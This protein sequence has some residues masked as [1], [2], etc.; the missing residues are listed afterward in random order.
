MNKNFALSA[1]VAAVPVAFAQGTAPSTN[2]QLYG[3]VDAGVTQTTGLRG[4]SRPQLVSGIMEGTRWGMRGNEDLGG[5]Y[6][7]DLQP[8]QLQLASANGHEV[9]TEPFTV[10]LDESDVKRLALDKS[11][12]SRPK[13][14]GHEVRVVGTVR[15][16]KSLAAP[17]MF[18]SLH[19]AR[20]LL[21]FLA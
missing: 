14:N 11:D 10:V 8:T 2:V 9:L 19:T 5:G 16:L 15:G 1:L 6:R 17:W 13:I 3:I 21:G 18:C 20:Q 7:A 12:G 4:G